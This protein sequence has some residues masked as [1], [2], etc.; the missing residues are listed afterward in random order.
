MISK[1]LF[2]EYLE[3]YQKFNEAFERIEEAL[4]GRK[5]SSNMFESDWYNSVGIMLDVFLESHFTENGRDLIYWWLFE[6]VDHI[7]WQTVD[8]DLFHGKSEIEY[9]VNNIEDLYDYLV[10]FKKDYIKDA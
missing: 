4:M 10:K 3:Q 5:Y 8:P 1:E 9:N 2:V 7:I 6:D